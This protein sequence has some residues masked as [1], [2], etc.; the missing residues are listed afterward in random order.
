MKQGL[1]QIAVDDEIIRETM[2]A[3]D[4]EVTH[5]RVRTLL[6]NLEAN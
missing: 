5:P 2:V 4:G 1:P 6:E 3:R